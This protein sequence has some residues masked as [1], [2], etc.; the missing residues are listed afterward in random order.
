MR[1]ERDVLVPLLVYG[2]ARQS[3]LSGNRGFWGL[4]ALLSPCG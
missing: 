2:T 1:F 3:V 4:A